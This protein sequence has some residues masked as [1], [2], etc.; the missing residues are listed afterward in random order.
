MLNDLSEYSDMSFEQQARNRNDIEHEEWMI[1]TDLKR[2][3]RSEVQNEPGT[4]YF[5]WL[6]D[7][8]KYTAQQT[9]EMPSWI[10]TKRDQ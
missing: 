6:S 4:E 9:G 10:K 8:L 1:L 2:P 3:F 5:D 7:R